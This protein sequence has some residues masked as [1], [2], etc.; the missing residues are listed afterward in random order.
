MH[1]LQTPAKRKIHLVRIIIKNML[2]QVCHDQNKIKDHGHCH[3][4]PASSLPVMRVRS[5]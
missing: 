1:Y 5:L 4:Y 3:Q 2:F